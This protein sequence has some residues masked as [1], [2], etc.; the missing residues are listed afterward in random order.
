MPAWPCRHLGARLRQNRQQRLDQSQRPAR[1]G[2]G[3]LTADL[4]VGA[5]DERPD[6]CRSA[7]EG[8]ADECA[9][10]EFDESDPAVSAT[11]IVAVPVATAA[12]IPN[13]T[14]N[15]PMRP[16]NMVVYRTVFNQTA[17]PDGPVADHA[18]LPN[19]TGSLAMQRA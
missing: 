13:P 17:T 8:E 9:T 3:E 16:K 12:P 7:A 15:A 2:P 6:D 18:R 14:A 4:D 11:A 10:D 19:A 1:G 5:V